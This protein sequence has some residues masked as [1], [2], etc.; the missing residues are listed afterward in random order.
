MVTSDIDFFAGGG[1]KFFNKRTDEKNLLE[2]LKAKG[3]GLDTTALG[4]F[5]GIKQYLK[6]AYLLAENRMEFIILQMKIRALKDKGK[7]YYINN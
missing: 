7:G 6:M 2:E 4:D 1:T 5:A 3:F